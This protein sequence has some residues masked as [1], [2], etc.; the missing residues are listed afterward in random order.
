MLALHYRAL[1]PCLCMAYSLH[2]VLDAKDT[3]ALGYITILFSEAYRND[4][5]NSMYTYLYDKC[6]TADLDWLEPT[7]GTFIRTMWDV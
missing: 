6:V 5:I 1:N 2:R 3:E 4:A 7:Y